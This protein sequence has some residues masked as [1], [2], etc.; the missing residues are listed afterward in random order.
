[1][2]NPKDFVFSSWAEWAGGDRACG[3]AFVRRR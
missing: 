1:M 3:G 2:R